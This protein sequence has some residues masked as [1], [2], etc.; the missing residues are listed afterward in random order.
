MRSFFSRDM[1]E[2]LAAGL[3]LATATGAHTPAPCRI[4]PVKYFVLNEEDT[5][6][7]VPDRAHAALQA[8]R[9]DMTASWCIYRRSGYLNSEETA[10][11]KGG[12]GTTWRF[13]DA[14]CWASGLTSPVA[15]SISQIAVRLSIPAMTTVL[16]P[17]SAADQPRAAMRSASTK[18]GQVSGRCVSWHQMSRV[19]R[20]QQAP[21]PL[22][23]QEIA[24]YVKG[25]PMP[26]PVA[27]L[28][29]VDEAVGKD[30]VPPSVVRLCS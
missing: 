12:T 7:Y 17:G 10:R 11:V 24:S 9:V 18:S 3:T 5:G 28:L 20:A 8:R 2:R 27:L 26:D 13:C 16:R 19:I 25:A 6:G 30:W 21:A 4:F 1:G 22:L 29:V 23:H 14:T 15:S